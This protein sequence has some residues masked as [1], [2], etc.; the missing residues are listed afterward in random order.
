MEAV[1]S[2]KEWPG[3]GVSSLHKAI[4]IGC[5]VA[6]HCHCLLEIPKAFMQTKVDVNGVQVNEGLWC[7][8]TNL[9]SSCHTQE[10]E[11]LVEPAS[12]QVVM[13]HYYHMWSTY[14]RIK[15]IEY[16][17]FVQERFIDPQATSMLYFFSFFFFFT[18]FIQPDVMF[19]FANSYFGRN[20]V[21]YLIK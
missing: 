7:S 15:L 18:L 14:E 17:I 4:V 1:I 11:C 16:V 5:Q 3:G 20:Y 8:N 12:H 10:F 21:S 9:F 19:M 6:T 13:R 2:G